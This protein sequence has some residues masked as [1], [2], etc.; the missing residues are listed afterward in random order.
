MKRILNYFKPNIFRV[1]LC[2]FIKITGVILELFIPI[3][4][5]HILDVVVVTGT[6][7]DI[8][9]YGVL[10]LLLSA[11]GFLGNCKANQIAAGLAKGVTLNLR[12]DL[13]TKIMSL[14]AEQIDN[15][16]M[17]SLVARMSSDTYNIHQMCGM[18]LRLGVRAPMLLI[19][20]T[21]ATLFLDP[22]L[23]LIML[24]ILP[25]VAVVLYFTSK[26]GIPLYSSVQTSIDQMVL[27]L[28]ENMSGVR[29]IKALSKEDY[30]K[31]RFDKVN[32]E[33]MK[34]EL[35]SSNTMATLN[36]IINLILNFGLILVIVIGA[37]RVNSGVILPAKV[38]AFTTFFTMI[39]NALIALNR[40]ITVISKAY[41][42]S[43][44]IDYIFDLGCDLRKENLT[45]SSKAYIEFKKV[46]FSYLGIK[47]NLSNISF[48]IDKGETLGIIGSTGS[49]KSTIINL[50]L[51]L[52]DVN[53][54]AIYINGKDIRNYS[55]QKLKSFFGT[56]LQ[57]DTLFAD[58]IFNNVDF[59]R[60]ISKK[61]VL[62]ALNDA[63]AYFVENLDKK[64]ET[65]LSAKGTN[66][67][68]GQRQRLIIARA[69][70]NNP[71]ILI[72]D[73]SSSALD[74]KTDSLLRKTLKEKYLKTTQ[75]I[76]SARI[77]SIMHADKIIVLE[78]GMISGLGTHNQ[79]LKTCDIY[80]EIY[81]SQLGG[82]VNEQ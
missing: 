62:K 5:S 40:M 53:E 15:V 28:R 47:N 39:L 77:S 46:S 70:A 59:Y 18:I 76:V 32:S 30:E 34:Y 35:K 45:G 51:R 13:F 66:L 43:K 75:I 44:R 64:E 60:G 73:D 22:M 65:I 67:S 55:P 82:D 29:V 72:L 6:I 26:I 11:G 68:G 23:T 31:K 74:Y 69:I 49:G 79:L 14:S 10:M 1:I 24:L 57:Y 20:G 37:M 21:I 42:S 3:V 56:A 12:K 16:T 33:V 8:V 78:D 50:L 54:G 81:D 48:K 63:Q 71:K 25:L 2:L 19:G 17:P 52:Y 36:P 7:T 80:K 38:L 41:A 27:T 4:L 58:T 9:W 61:N